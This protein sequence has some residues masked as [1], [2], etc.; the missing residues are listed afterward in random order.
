MD[1][2]V[3]PPATTLL[4][5]VTTPEDRASHSEVEH[6]HARIVD[7]LGMSRSVLDSTIEPLAILN[8]H[9]QIIFH[10][11]AMSDLAGKRHLLGMRPGEAL[12][13]LHHAETRSGCG[14]APACRLCGTLQTIEEAQHQGGTQQGEC[15]MTRVDGFESTCFNG[16]VRAGKLPFEDAIVLSLRDTESHERRAVLERTFFHDILNTAGGL[17][18]M[19]ELLAETREPERDF[20]VRSVFDLARQLVEEIRSGRDLAAAELGDLCVTLHHT[21]VAG[22]L[23]RVVSTVEH[24]PVSAGRLIQASCSRPCS[25]LTDDVLLRRCLVNL[26]KNAVEATQ[27][28]GTVVIDYDYRGGHVFSVHNSAFMPADIQQQVFQRSFS[29]KNEPGRGIGTYSVKLLAE[30]YLGGSVNFTSSPDE[31]TVFSIFLPAD[32]MDAAV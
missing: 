5:T 7:L 25:I 31:G 24:N 2:Q 26:A 9:R 28:G 14:A 8:A 27:P 22:L 6:Q 30:K 18:G 23:R 1:P 21:D 3:P 15:R 11:A 13:C 12:D 19:V 16:A 17:L 4:A 32:F 20:M 10:N 29:T